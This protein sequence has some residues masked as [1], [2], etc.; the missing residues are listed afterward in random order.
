MTSALP[1]HWED[2]CHNQH[3]TPDLVSTMCGSGTSAVLIE[4]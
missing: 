4:I 3:L 1:V 2:F